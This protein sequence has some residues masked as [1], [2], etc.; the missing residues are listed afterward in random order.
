MKKRK[1]K[2]RVSGYWRV[3]EAGTYYIKGYLRKRPSKKTLK[4]A[5]KQ[6]A[7]TVKRKTK[8]RYV[9]HHIG[10]DKYQL[11]WTW[12]VL[13]LVPLGYHQK[14]FDTG[15]QEKE[16]FVEQY[17]HTKF[18]LTRKQAKVELNRLINETE[19]RY[20]SVQWESFTLYQVGGPGP[21]TEK[22]WIK[23]GTYTKDKLPN[24]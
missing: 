19:E 4:A 16:V 5:S 24:R 11:A 1:T 23:H 18:A 7:A 3:T 20:D 21:I 9:E 22:H 2:A 10:E 8:R 12:K 13:V 14:F 17:M 6:R 15:E